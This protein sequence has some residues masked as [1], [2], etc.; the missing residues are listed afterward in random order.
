M[1][2]LVATGTTELVEASP[3][4]KVWGVG[5]SADD[6]LIHDKRNWLGLNL[7]GKVLMQV[8]DKILRNR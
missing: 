1:D 3:F 2:A 4:D 5:L 7:L 8:R 6:P